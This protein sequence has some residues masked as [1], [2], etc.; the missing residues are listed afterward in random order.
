MLHR[1]SWMTTPAFVVQAVAG[2]IADIAVL[3]GQRVLPAKAIGLKFGFRY[4]D[5]D[6][7]LAAAML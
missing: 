1:P 5:V 4:P 7:A 6:Q 2:E 3:A